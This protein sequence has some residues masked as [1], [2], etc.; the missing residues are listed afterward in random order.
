MESSRQGYQLHMVKQIWHSSN[1]WIRNLV[2]Y[3]DGLMQER[4]N[5]IANAL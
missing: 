3:I 5:F 2:D 1:H 4:R